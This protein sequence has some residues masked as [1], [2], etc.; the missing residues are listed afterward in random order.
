MFV[1]ENYPS[2][3]RIHLLHLCFLQFWKG[4]FTF[5]FGGKFVTVRFQSF[6]CYQQLFIEIQVCDISHQND[7]QLN[8]HHLI[9][10]CFFPS[11]EL[12][13]LCYD[14]R[15]LWELLKA[16]LKKKKNKSPFLSPAKKKTVVGFWQEGL[17]SCFSSKIE[18][19]QEK[20]QQSTDC[21]TVQ[22]DK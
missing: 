15:S 4:F 8:D 12:Y 20:R 18:I 11:R 6:V 7:P 2:R 21:K 10:S 17:I 9:E 13:V 16:K 3:N 22:K 14:K 5:H 19:M 1:K